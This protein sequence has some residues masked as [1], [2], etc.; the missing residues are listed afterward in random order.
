M[1]QMAGIFPRETHYCTQLFAFYSLTSYAKE[2]RCKTDKCL[3][4][5]DFNAARQPRN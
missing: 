1:A 5:I 3:R 4:K 2:F